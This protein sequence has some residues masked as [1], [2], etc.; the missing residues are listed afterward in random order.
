MDVMTLLTE[1][2]PV[3]SSAGFITFLSA[4]QVNQYMTPIVQQSVKALVEFVPKSVANLGSNLPGAS[5]VRAIL[6]ML[7][8]ITVLGLIYAFVI[9]PLYSD[10]MARVNGN[11]NQ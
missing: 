9:E 11:M 3:I 4:L 10:T 7:L 5:I 1:L 8:A 2:G 6:A